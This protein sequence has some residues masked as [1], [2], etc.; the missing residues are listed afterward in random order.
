MAVKCPKCKTNNPGTVKFCGECGIP[1]EANV[2]HTKTLETPKEEL[3]RE[4][5]F[6]G[7][8]GIIEELGKG[9]IGRFLGPLAMR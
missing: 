6:Y 4:T 8:Y 7:R 5:V 3:T 1:L 9:G 2:F